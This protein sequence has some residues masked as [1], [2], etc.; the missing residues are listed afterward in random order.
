MV[1]KASAVLTSVRITSFNP[2]E[3][4]SVRR[5]WFET[6]HSSWQGQMRAARLSTSSR[7]YDWPTT[8]SRGLCC[9]QIRRK[10]R[11]YAAKRSAAATAATTVGAVAPR[12]VAPGVVAPGAVAPAAVAATVGVPTPTTATEGTAVAE[13]EEA[14]LRLVVARDAVKGPLDVV[15]GAVVAALGEVMVDDGAAREIVRLDTVLLPLPSCP[16]FRA[17]TAA[18]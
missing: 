8:R 6:D 16:R 2:P 13:P 11:R 1:S 14:R 3:L 4:L 17:R 12:V 18:E 15:A 9:G 7:P 5:A 10:T